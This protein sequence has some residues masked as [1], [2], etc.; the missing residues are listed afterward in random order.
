LRSAS[1]SAPARGV[2]THCW[3]ADHCAC[4]AK[5]ARSLSPAPVTAMLWL[6]L[7]PD[8][9]ETTA[10]SLAM[11]PEIRMFAAISGSANLMLVV[12]LNSQNDT[13]QLESSLV[14]KLP[15][16]EIV[17]RAVTLRAIKLMGRLLD[18]SG[19]SDGRVPLDFWAEV[20]PRTR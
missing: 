2:S 9:L 10:R 1:T 13:V 7:P 3:R 16:L 14:S 15:W 18:Y 19:R 5:I 20:R 12:W 4:A 17:D 11:L 8:K 6:R